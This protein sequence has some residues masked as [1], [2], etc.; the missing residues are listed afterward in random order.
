MPLCLPFSF[1]STDRFWWKERRSPPVS[2]ELEGCRRHSSVPKHFEAAAKPPVPARRTGLAAGG[3]VPSGWVCAA[4]WRLR[5]GQAAGG[6]TGCAAGRRGWMLLSL[7]RR[8]LCGVSEQTAALTTPPCPSPG[9]S[10]AQ[11]ASAAAS[12]TCTR[13]ETSSCQHT[14]SGRQQRKLLSSRTFPAALRPGSGLQEDASCHPEQLRRL[15][16]VEE[17]ETFSGKG[18][19]PLS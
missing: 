8:D 3:P 13:Q 9:L 12:Q 2:C 15:R 19:K 4:L 7:H 14:G 6:R 11:G 18:V 17:E 1:L 10:G 16:A 5:A